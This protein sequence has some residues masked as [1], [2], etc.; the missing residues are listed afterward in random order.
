MTAT[1]ATPTPNLGTSVIPVLMTVATAIVTPTVTIAMPVLTTVNA[2]IATPTTGIAAMLTLMT[3]TAATETPTICNVAIQTSAVSVAPIRRRQHKTKLE[4]VVKEGEDEEQGEG[5]FGTEQSVEE[6]LE[7]EVTVRSLFLKEL[8]GVK[9]DFSLHEGEPIAT[10]LIQCWDGRAN[11]LELE[12][13]EA[14]Q[15]ESPA[16][17][18]GIDKSIGKRKQ[19]QSLWR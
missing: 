3:A 9:K 13:N 4:S 14:R 10:W 2:A 1:V 16:R 15:L 7:P 6:E 12:S 19:S 8:R 17:D 11:S 18:G 5:T